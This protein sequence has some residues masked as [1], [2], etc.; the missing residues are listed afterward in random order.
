MN[1]LKIAAVCMHAETGEIKNNLAKMMS[2]VSVKP[3]KLEQTSY[4]FLN[5]ALQAIL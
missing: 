1:D 4:A 5:F 2:I 3:L